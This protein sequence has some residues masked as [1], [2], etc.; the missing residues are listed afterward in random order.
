MYAYTKR[1]F[2]FVFL[3][4]QLWKI[5]GWWFTALCGGVYVMERVCWTNCAKEEAFKRQF[6]DYASEKLQSEVSVMSVKC[7]GKVRQ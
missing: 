5:V 2:Q 7:S 4:L 1:P 6:V 3:L